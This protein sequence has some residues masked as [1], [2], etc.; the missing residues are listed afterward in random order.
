MCLYPVVP[1]KMNEKDGHAFF[2]E[3][4]HRGRGRVEQVFGKFNRLR[5]FA[6]LSAR[7]PRKK[8]R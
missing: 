7:R 1:P 4:L 5:R 2:A 6:L 8:L 3:A